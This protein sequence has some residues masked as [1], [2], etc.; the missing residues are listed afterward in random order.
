MRVEIN[1]PDDYI[2]DIVGDVA[3]RRGNVKSMEKYRERSQKV[4]ASVPLM[5]MFGYAT[6]LRNISS[7]R[8]N[9]SMEFESYEQIAKDLQEKVLK[10]FREAKAEGK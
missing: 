9:Y 3:R 7:G 1:T 4:R 6:N 10:D 5:Q 2:G 8:A